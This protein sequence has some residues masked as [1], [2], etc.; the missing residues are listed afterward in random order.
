MRRDGRQGRRGRRGRRGRQGSSW[1]GASLGVA[2]VLLVAAACVPPPPAESYVALGDSFTAGPLIPSQS[3]DPLGCLRSTSNYPSELAPRLDLELRD[4]SCSGAETDDMFAE[5]GVTPGPN[6]PQLD[7]LDEHTGLVTLGIGGND[8]GFSSI[9]ADCIELN[10]WGPGC[11]GDFVSGGTDEISDDIAATAPKVAAVVAEVHDRAPE[12]DVFVVGYPTILPHTGDGCWPAVPIVP[13]DVEYLRAK[14]Q[15]LNA[16][17]AAVAA[18]NGAVFVDTY[19]P[20]IGRD[21]CQ[22]A[23]TKWVEGLVPTSAAAPVHPNARGMAGTADV[24]ADAV[25]AH[26]DVL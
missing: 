23:G 16:M 24:V 18:A 2:V 6:P 5:Q 25:A 26:S 9:V 11:R 3:L 15:E 8:I 13:S 12:A 14:H 21:A 19:T 22:D 20:S 17:L 1:R 10:P 7:A 4:V